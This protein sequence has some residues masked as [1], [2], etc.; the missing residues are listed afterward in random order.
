MLVGICPELGVAITEAAR[1]L[2]AE[3]KRGPSRSHLRQC[4]GPTPAEFG[5]T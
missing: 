5:P 1:R 3:V 4:W 2:E